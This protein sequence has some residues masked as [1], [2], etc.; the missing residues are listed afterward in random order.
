M[1]PEPANSYDESSAKRDGLEFDQSQQELMDDRAIKEV[2]DDLE[3]MKERLK[4]A[5]D[6]LKKQDLELEIE[7]VQDLLR[8]AEFKGQNRTFELTEIKRARTE[9]SKT[10]FIST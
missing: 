9:H 10:N 1:N 8:Q 6:I 2:K 5:T 3:D 4:S 7:K